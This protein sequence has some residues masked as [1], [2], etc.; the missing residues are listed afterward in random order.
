MPERVQVHLG[1]L[2][3]ERQT[4]RELLDYLG[5][6]SPTGCPAG[7]SPLALDADSTLRGRDAANRI[8][9]IELWG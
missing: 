5:P 8:L 2:A 7:V 3:E 6:Q 9:S 1:V 4:W